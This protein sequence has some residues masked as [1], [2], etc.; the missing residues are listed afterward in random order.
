VL[1]LTSALLG[2]LWNH[3]WPM[4][5][6][7]PV[8]SSSARCCGAVNGFLVTALGLP[9]L[10]VTIGTLALYRGL[11]FV[12]LGDQAVTDFPQTTP[13]GLRHV[14]RHRDPE[15]DDPV[16][17][18]RRDL[19]RRA[20]PHG[21]RPL[22]L[23]D[24]RQRGGGALLRACASSAIKFWLF[25]VSGAVSALAGIVYTLPL[26]QRAA[27]NGTGLELSV[28]A[29]CCS[30]ACRSSA[31]AAPARRHRR[32]VPAR[33]APQRADAQQRLRRRADDRHRRPAAAL[34][35]RAERHRAG[36]EALRR[37][38]GTPPPPRPNHHPCEEGHVHIHLEVA[39]R[40]AGAR[41]WRRS[42]AVRLDQETAP[43]RARAA[44]AS[45]DGGGAGQA[46]AA[47]K[48]GLK[49]AFLPKQLN[50]PYFTISDKG[51]KEAVKE[52]GGDVQAR[53]PV[54]RDASS[55]V[56]Y[57]NTLTT[58]KVGR[59]R[60]L[61]QR[62]ERGRAGAQEGDERRASRSSPTTPTPRPTGRD[63]FINQASAEDLGRSEVQL[64]AKQ[65][66]NKGEIAILS[67][68]PN[69]TNQN[70]WIKFMKD[71]LKPSRSTRT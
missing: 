61:G 62:P 55:Q 15:P 21:R 17:G 70:T 29:A 14:R 1:G 2:Y 67:A 59:D 30:A 25:V 54:R 53:R 35:P 19:R 49:I 3:G 34:R 58:Q 56:S 22:D 65:I 71:E 8:A 20:A 27:D 42:P 11:A 51:G 45:V 60:D 40:R 10:A 57:I 43:R 5:L 41:A 26:R 63:L 48:K 6:I 13:T 38:A 64:L 4:E 16:R 39:R 52:L 18:P 33:H 46:S 36:R 7:I 28:V 66:G 44:A 12:I 31:A 32:R 47:I 68:T 69:A 50:N 9:S 23:R 37:R 24:R